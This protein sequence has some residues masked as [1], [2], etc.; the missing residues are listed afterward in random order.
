[1]NARLI[2]SA[3]SELIMSFFIRDFDVDK[4]RVERRNQKRISNSVFLGKIRRQAKGLNGVFIDIGLDREAYLPYKGMINNGEDEYECNIPTVGSYM[5][6]Q[7][8]REPV[9]DKGAKVSCKISLPGRFIVYLPNSRGVYVSGKIDKSMKEEFERLLSPH[10]QGDGLIVRTSALLARR[11]DVINELRRAQEMWRELTKRMP[12]NKVGMVYEEVPL[13]LEMI[14]DYWSCIDEIVVDD[15]EVWDRVM[16]FLEDF[17]PEMLTRVRYVKNIDTFL[18]RYDIDKVLNR[19]FSKYVWLN[20]GGY[21]VIEETEAM[22]VIDVNSGS[23]LGDS[24]EEN[25]L[26]TNLEAAEEIARQIKLRDLGGIIVIDFID[27]K[28][29]RNRDIVVDRLRKAFEDEASKV[30]IYGITHL[31]LLEMTRKK[32]T[33]S[34]TKQLSVACPYCRSKGFMKSPEFVVYEI[35]KELE[36]LKG[37]KVELRINP[38]IKESVEEFIKRRKLNGWITLKEECDAPLD[39]YEM[40]YVG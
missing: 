26:R 25:A 37:K 28:N 5:L 30:K 14:R 36:Y 35:E 38:I 39:Y 8:K 7:V 9:G 12:K 13:Y 1:M 21:L 15:V 40:T 2:V 6:V 17:Y 29:K 32:E 20:S 16:A 31:G 19:I 3:S 33:K 11:E 22:T 24:L 4:I 27:M 10:L 18:K 23:G 34:I